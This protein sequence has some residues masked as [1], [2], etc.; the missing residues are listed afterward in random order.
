MVK[1]LAFWGYKC[2]S[3]DPKM[4]GGEGAIISTNIKKYMRNLLY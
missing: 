3:S 4:I 2:K 1:L